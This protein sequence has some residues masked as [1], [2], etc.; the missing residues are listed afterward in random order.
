MSSIVVVV[1][2]IV[3]VDDVVVS[4]LT[5]IEKLCMYVVIKLLRNSQSSK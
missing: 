1:I 2:V 3:V 4:R 5:A